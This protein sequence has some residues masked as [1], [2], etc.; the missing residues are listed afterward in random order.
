MKTIQ[1]RIP[2]SLHREILKIKRDKENEY[3]IYG[4]RKRACTF[5]QAAAIYQKDK[6]YSFFGGKLL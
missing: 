3:K 1:V 6:N 5:V 4:G 2:V